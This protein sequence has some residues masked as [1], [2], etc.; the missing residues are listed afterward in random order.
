METLRNKKLTMCKQSGDSIP[1]LLI[2]VAAL[3]LVLAAKTFSAVVVGDSLSASDTDWCQYNN[4]QSRHYKCLTQSMRFAATYELP[5]DLD[6][7]DGH[8][9]LVYWL[10]TNDAL[11]WDDPVAQAS[12]KSAFQSQMNQAFN[13]GFNVLVILPPTVS[14]RDTS[15]PRSYL[16]LYVAVVA[17]YFNKP[18]QTV[19]PDNHNYQTT[20]CLHPTPLWSQYWGDFIHQTITAWENE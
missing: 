12:I 9:T 6:N 17:L 16:Q 10:M 14:C 19:D 20:D 13:A 7:V 8:N 5:P 1:A 18:I 11:F 4:T 15:G 3:F 2:I